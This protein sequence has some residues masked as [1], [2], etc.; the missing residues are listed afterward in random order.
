MLVSR[1]GTGYCDP[2]IKGARSIASQLSRSKQGGG[3][4]ADTSCFVD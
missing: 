2:E 3:R 1:M 4:G